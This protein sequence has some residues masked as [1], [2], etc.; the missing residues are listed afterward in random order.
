M[1][2]FFLRQGATLEIHVSKKRP[3]FAKIYLKC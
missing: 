3:K 1:Q 2:A